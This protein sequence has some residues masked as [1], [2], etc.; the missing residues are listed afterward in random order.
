MEDSTTTEDATQG[1]VPGAQFIDQPRGVA[2]DPGSRVTAE[3]QIFGELRFT[4]E[5]APQVA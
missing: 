3:N 5:Y 2:N 4:E 1:V